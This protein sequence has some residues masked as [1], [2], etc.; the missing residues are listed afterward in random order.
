MFFLLSLVWLA[1]I[2]V[3]AQS[4]PR[5]ET[6]ET[7]TAQLADL[8]SQY[9]QRDPCSSDLPPEMRKY[10]IDVQVKLPDRNKKMPWSAL[11]KGKYVQENAAPILFVH[12]G[13]GQSW[14]VPFAPLVLDLLSSHRIKFPSPIIVYDQAGS[15][16]SHGLKPLIG[17]DSKDTLDLYTQE[18]LRVMDQHQVSKAHLLGHSFGSNIVASFTGK[19]R[20]RVEGVFFGSPSFDVPGWQLTADFHMAYLLTFQSVV[21]A[22]ESAV[23]RR[24]ENKNSRWWQRH[25]KMS[26]RMRLNELLQGEVKQENRYNNKFVLGSH[27]LDSIPFCN[28]NGDVYDKV[29]GSSEFNVSGQIK[30]DDW[31]F[32]FSAVSDAT[33]PVF[34]IAGVA[35]EVS[36]TSLLHYENFVRKRSIEQ[37]LG[38]SYERIIVLP[39][40]PHVWDYATDGR[41]LSEAISGAVRM[42]NSESGK[43]KHML[44]QQ[45]R[46]TFRKREGF[47][48]ARPSIV[49]LRE[50]FQRAMPRIEEIRTVQL[51]RG[52]QLSL[53]AG[54]GKVP[55]EGGDKL[56][57]RSHAYLA[58]F[59]IHGKLPLEDLMREVPLLQRPASS[60]LS[61]EINDDEQQALLDLWYMAVVSGHLNARVRFAPHPSLVKAWHDQM[62]GEICRSK[63]PVE[64]DFCLYF[65][66]FYKSLDRI[67]ELAAAIG[68]PVAWQTIAQVG[69]IAIPFSPRLGKVFNNK[70]YSAPQLLMRNEMYIYLL[71]HVVLYETDWFNMNA[72]RSRNVADRLRGSIDVGSKQA[73]EMREAELR[74]AVEELLHY[75][76]LTL[77]TYTRDCQPTGLA[78][79]DLV[80]EIVFVLGKMVGPTHPVVLPLALRMFETVTRCVE[81]KEAIEEMDTHLASVLVSSAMEM[82]LT[83]VS[84]AA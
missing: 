34:F 4:S 28:P 73:Q 68:P 21:N 26:V 47:R 79:Y 27:S 81:G 31:E 55:I 82:N 22:D 5:A 52:R 2:I 1:F 76:P 13:P 66:I 35:D 10:L 58:T 42:I 14:V 84:D 20:D 64:T 16:R 65:Y 9:F 51:N 61:T 38:L 74:G 44:S 23:V 57:E 8:V 54:R 72:I 62:T 78:P 43:S 29:W 15:G 11:F 75:A 25:L 63:T 19:H 24:H 46:R 18:L 36:P 3:T 12:G 69:G 83:Q 53:K 40:S 59:I 32:V 70:P 49:V 17:K 60:Y 71:T 39:H 33:F 77:P 56:V 30:N 7:G 50:A 45:H 37:A 67:G 6:D 48:F 80:G 41:I